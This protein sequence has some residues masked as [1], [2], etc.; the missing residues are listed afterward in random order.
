MAQNI[1]PAAQKWTREFKQPPAF[2][3]FAAVAA[4]KHISPRPPASIVLI[5]HHYL[6]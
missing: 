2:A 5:P 3:V 6:R 4:G 1:S